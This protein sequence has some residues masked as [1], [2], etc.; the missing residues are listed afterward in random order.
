[1]KN[2]ILIV[3]TV[4]LVANQ[5]SAQ[6]PDTLWSKTYGGATYDWGSS[7]QETSD[8]GYIITGHTYSFGEGSRDVYLIRT[9]PDV[10]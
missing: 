7:L 6:T 3:V 4:L 2:Y 10:E 8:G 5:I 9:V 1:M